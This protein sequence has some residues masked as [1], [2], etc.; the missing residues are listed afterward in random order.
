MRKQ[1]DLVTRT[2][3]PEV[4]RHPQWTIE[5]A[6]GQ[7]LCDDRGTLRWFDTRPVPV[8][9]GDALD[10]TFLEHCARARRLLDF[11]ACAIFDALLRLIA[12]RCAGRTRQHDRVVSPGPDR[13]RTHTSRSSRCG[14]LHCRDRLASTCWFLPSP[15]FICA[16]KYRRDGRQSGRGGLHWPSLVLSCQADQGHPYQG[17]RCRRRPTQSWIRRKTVR[18]VTLVCARADEREIQKRYRF[19]G[20]PSLIFLSHGRYLGCIER[21]LDWAIP[22]SESLQICRASRMTRPHSACPNIAPRPPAT[23]APLPCFPVHSRISP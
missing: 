17:R 3:A 6:E 4:R 9:P 10:M 20:F 2:A 19:T 13:T 1:V 12:A 8:V 14:K 15:S 5:V 16:Q 23:D 21:V 22:R 18:A 11:S 7:A